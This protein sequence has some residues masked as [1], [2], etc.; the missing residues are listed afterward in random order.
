MDHNVFDK[1]ASKYDAWFIKNKNVLE[2][3]VALVAYFLKKPGKAISVG[4]GSGLFEMLLKKMY[5]IIIEEGIEPAFGMAEIAEKR[6]MKI[7]KVSAEEIDLGFEEYDTVIFNGTPSYISDLKKAFQ[8]TN[9][10]LKKGGKL[11]VVDVPKESSYGILYNLAAKIGDWQDPIFQDAK[12][13]DVYPIEFV[14]A[15]NWRST[16]EKIELLKKCGFG[17]FQFAQT[18]TTHPA[19][20]NFKKEEPQE[21][22]DK[23]DYVAIFAQK[24]ME[25]SDES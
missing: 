7:K 18:L 4:C 8:K 1:Y 11:L 15:A 25:V 2:S 12:P 20:S 21:G 17:K 16:P 23:G 3:E 13:E 14:K 22:F 5:G 6:G 10:A 9:R 19:Y 24:I